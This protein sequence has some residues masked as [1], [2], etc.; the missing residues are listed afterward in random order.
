MNPWELLAED[1]TRL[2]SGFDAA[3]S[4]GA[5]ATLLDEPPEIVY[6]TEETGGAD[7]AL[8]GIP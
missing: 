7:D 8:G 6:H 1:A 2:D 3:P 5:M 4:I